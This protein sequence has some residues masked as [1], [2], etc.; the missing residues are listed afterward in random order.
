MAEGAKW[1][2]VN[3]A[4]VEER[5]IAERYFRVREKLKQVLAAGVPVT[6]SRRGYGCWDP[7][8]QHYWE[9][10]LLWFRITDG[11]ACEPGSDWVRL[12]RDGERVFDERNYAG[13]VR[14]D[15]PYMSAISSR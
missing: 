14:I 15:K 2:S 1:R 5:D 13:K 7:F 3:D 6:W 10:R 8:P 4:P 12:D 9:V 11:V